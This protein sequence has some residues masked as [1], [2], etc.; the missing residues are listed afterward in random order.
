MIYHILIVDDEAAIKKGLSMLIQRSLPN[1]VLDGTASDGAEAIEIIKK[2]PPD[3]VIT[4]IKMPVCNGLELSRFIYENYPDIKIIMLTGFADFEYA[5]TAIKYRVSDYLLKPTSKDKLLDAIT[6]IQSEISELRK[7][8]GFLQKNSFLFVE[9]ALQEVA[10]GTV[11]DEYY[12]SISSCWPD[13]N[14]SYYCISLQCKDGESHEKSHTTL[15]RSILEQQLQDSF[16][17]RYNNA[18]NCLYFCKQ[19]DVAQEHKV[20]TFAQEILNDMLPI[21]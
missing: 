7:K 2:A 12:D 20:I 17:F 21:E 1:C 10:S 3:I 5:Q 18:V 4:D 15:I 14:S 13:E 8:R 19:G 9:R 6:K 11:T 16:V